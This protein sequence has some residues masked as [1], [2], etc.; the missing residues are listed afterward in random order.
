MFLILRKNARS[1]EGWASSLSCPSRTTP[2]S[3]TPRTARATPAPRWG[4]P[5]LLGLVLW[6][7]RLMPLR[8]L[9]VRPRIQRKPMRYL[10][11]RIFP[12]WKSMCACQSHWYVLFLSPFEF[13]LSSLFHHMISLTYTVCLTVFFPPL[14]IY[15]HN[16][17]SQ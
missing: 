4:N 17:C 11:E 13:F 6:R 15:R 12:E 7:T 9:Q 14:L 1:P 3:R 16:L 5:L 10:R 2:A 8:R